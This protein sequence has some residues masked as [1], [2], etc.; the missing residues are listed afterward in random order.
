MR[1]LKNIRLFWPLKRR[2]RGARHLWKWFLNLASLWL[3][4]VGKSRWELTVREW[5]NWE[6]WGGQV[7]PD[8]ISLKLFLALHHHHLYQCS[9]TIS[10]TKSM[11]FFATSNHIF[12][13]PMFDQTIRY[14][15]PNVSI[16]NVQNLHKFLA[17]KNLSTSSTIFLCVKNCASWS[18]HFI[19]TDK[20]RLFE[21]DESP[22]FWN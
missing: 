21:E 22:T 2:R 8:K 13:D 6:L 18:V 14:N 7:T 17:Q 12:L 1:G 5:L 9:A 4:K 15:I 11:C 10:R 20:K 19:S 16:C 3:K